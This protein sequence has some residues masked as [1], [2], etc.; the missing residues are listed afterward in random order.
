MVNNVSP[1]SSLYSDSKL[2]GLIILYLLKSPAGWNPAG[3][4]WVPCCYHQNYLP[5]LP[6]EDS[7]RWSKDKKQGNYEGIK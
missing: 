1:F 4:Q 2:V 6:F 3:E 5:V 7:E